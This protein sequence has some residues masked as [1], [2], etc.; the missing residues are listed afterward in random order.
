MIQTVVIA[1]RDAAAWL[2][3]NVLHQALG[4]TGLNIKVVELPSLVRRQDIYPTLPALEPLHRLLGFDEH[5]VLR[6]TAGA[7]AMGQSFV[8]FAGP[9]TAF[10]HAYGSHGVGLDNLPFL[11]LYLRARQA[12][13]KVAIE[14]FSLTAAA[15]KQGRFIVPDTE[16]QLFARTD[17]GYHLP[18]DSYV[19]FLKQA[20]V[21]A[22]ISVHSAA[23]L[24]GESNSAGHLTA[25]ITGTGERVEGDLFIDA[26]GTDALL[27]R[28]ALRVPFD[29]WRPWFAADRVLAASGPRLKNLPPYGQIRANALGWLGLYAA[30]T[31]T[32]IV[33]VY[34][35]R[36][37]SDNDA[38]HGAA[39]VSGLVLGDAFVSPLEPGRAHQAWRGNCVAIGE[40]AC[41]FDPLDSPAL[42][43]VQTGLVH[44]LSLFPNRLEGPESAVYNRLM[45]QTFEGIRDFQLS[46]SALGRLDGAFWH[47]ARAVAPPPS[48]QRKLDAFAA[49]GLVPLDDE[50]TFLGDSWEAVM[51]GHG[52]IPQSH[53]PLADAVPDA[54][55]MAHLKRVLGHIKSQVDEGH[56]HDAYLE[57]FG[58]PETV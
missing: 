28:K 5:T 54:D 21:R 48:L 37:Q 8:N 30:Q 36:L 12:G 6:A 11:P 31:S 45:Q 44:L 50:E 1:G 55:L 3:A 23:T 43:A 53:E 26:T 58:A 42:Q 24:R 4:H 57:I 34:D 33:N 35:S 38:L 25:V 19:Q 51:L 47:D 20:A 14:D 56:A 2:S 49:R 27:L 9:G 46:H 29:S 40:A 41:V 22:G 16:T 15:A 13:L 39:V 7:Y 17:Y 10:F 52:L 32:H 18:A